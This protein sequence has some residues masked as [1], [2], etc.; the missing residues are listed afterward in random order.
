MLGEFAYRIEETDVWSSAGMT[1]CLALSQSSVPLTT[2]FVHEYM[3][4]ALAGEEGSVSYRPGGSND[5]A[6]EQQ[7]GDITQH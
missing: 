7:M 2:P 5:H 1:F 3:H 4:W 6:D